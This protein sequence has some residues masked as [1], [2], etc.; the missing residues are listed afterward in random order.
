[1]TQTATATLEWQR[2]PETL[3]LG[4]AR[5]LRAAGVPV[6]ADRET[7]FLE[8][9]SLVGMDEERRDLL[10]WT[11]DAV[12]RP[13]PHRALRPGVHRMVPRA[14]RHPGRHG[15]GRSGPDGFAR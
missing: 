10:G 13:G 8:A 12:L 4:F 6:T 9:V 11:G 5:A 2:P 15:A 14:H 1:M 3:L 7:S